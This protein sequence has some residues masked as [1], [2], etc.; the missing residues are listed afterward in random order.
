VR[1]RFGFYYFTI[2]SMVAVR[3]GVREREREGERE[4]VQSKAGE[5]GEIIMC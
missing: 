4:F 1:E 2:S 3:E 5:K